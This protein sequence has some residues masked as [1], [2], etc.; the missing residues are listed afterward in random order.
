MNLQRRAIKTANL[1]QRLAKLEQQWKLRD[2][3]SHEP[4]AA[5]DQDSGSRALGGEVGSAVS[6]FADDEV[7]K[8]IREAAE[9]SVGNKG[10]KAYGLADGVDLNKQWLKMP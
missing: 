8:I 9:T 3:A 10:T 6:D 4:A 5:C 7:T 2:S 1:E